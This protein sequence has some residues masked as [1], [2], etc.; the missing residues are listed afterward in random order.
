[1]VEYYGKFKD[2]SFL[3]LFYAS[4]I[5]I[6]L[7][8]VLSISVNATDYPL[9]NERY[10]Q[11]GQNANYYFTKIHKINGNEYIGISKDN[12]IMAV[13]DDDG[14]IGD[15][16]LVPSFKNPLDNNWYVCPI[17]NMDTVNSVTDLGNGWEFDASST[18]LTC[19]QKTNLANTI[20]VPINIILSFQT[21][22]SANTKINAI[23]TLN[24]VLTPNDTGFAFFFEPT[25]LNKY[26]YIE[27]NGEL[28]D[29][30]GVERNVPIQKIFD[31]FTNNQVNIGHS[32]NWGDMLDY[33]NRYSEILDIGG[34]TGFFVGTY[35]YGSSKIIN[36]DPIYSV[37]YSPIPA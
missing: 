7:A 16:W 34:H 19:R 4:L 36:I 2:E 32:F 6:I 24:T 14:Y 27:A 20:N 3:K 33:G 8:F 30:A 1:M 28:I 22:S 35:G 5:F 26:R 13:G 17:T 18:L 12:H 23:V 10:I 9:S 25:D 31:F 21:D 37:D 29:L 15:L 11:T